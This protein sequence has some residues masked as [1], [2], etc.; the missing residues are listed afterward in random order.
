MAECSIF[1]RWFSSNVYLIC[2]LFLFLISKSQSDDVGVL[3]QLKS[4]LRSADSPVFDTWT[5][6]NS[7]CNFTGVTCDSNHKVTEINLSLQNLSGPVSFDLICSLESLEKIS[8]GSNFLYGSI[9]DHLSNCTS[10]QHLD[11]GMNYFS[12][13]VP[14]L[15]S[16]TKLELL[17]LNHCGFSGSFP[18]SS[19]A[20]LTSLGFL[21]LGDNDFDRSPFPL[22]LLKLEKLYW[23]YL[24]NC[25]IEGQIPDGIGNLTLL[26]NLEL[27]YNN[28]VGSIP[29]GI[30]RLSKLNQLELYTNGLTGK[31]PVGFGNLTNLVK[32]D[33]STNYIEGDLSELRSLTQ[34]ASLQL[35]ENQ[36][37]GEV[38]QEFGE[39]KFLT[40]F[41]LYTN[42]LT[43][44]LPEKIGSWSEFLYIDVSGNF[45]TGPIPPDMC[46]GGKLSKLLMLQNGFTGGIPASYGN[47]LS[48]TRLRVS[49]NSLSGEV[50]SGIWGLPKVTIIDL[51]LNQFEG[52]VAPSIG[53]AKSLAELLLANNQFSGELPQR[54]SEAASLVKIDITSNKLSE[55]IPATIGNL[56]K[57]SYLHL[58]FNSF[59]GV[60]PDSLGSCA[61][62]NDIN[63]AHNSFSG[64]IPA[65]LGSLPSLN[66]LN[67][68]NN[69]FVGEIPL[70]FTSLPLNLLDLSNNRLVGHIPDSLSIDAFNGSFDGN[71]GL[72]SESL[73]SFR[74]C[75]S[76][77]GMSGKIKTVIYCF[78]AIAC[79]LIVTLTCC[80]FLRFRHKNGEIPVKRSD[81]WDMKLF[82][83]LSFSEEQI[84]KALKHENLVGKGGSGNVY[85]V[86]LHCGMQLAVKHIWNQDS[87]SRNSCRSTAAILAKGKGKGRS[88]EYD[89]EVA[90]LSSARHVNVVKLYC[91]I[92]TEDS[93]LLVYEYLPN[94]SLWDRLHTGQRIKMDWM[95]RYE[96][97][98]GAAK[99]LEYLHHGC[100]R[101]IIH[102]DV[103]SSNILL[104]ADLKPKIADFGLA[105]ILQANEP[106]ARES[107]HVIAGTPGYIAP[108]YAYACSV[109]EKSDVYSFGVVLMELVTGKKP[110]E[111]EFGD[112]KD[113][114]SWI[115]SKLRSEHRTIELVDKS[116]SEALR[117][118]AVKVL[119]IAI[120]CTSRT[121]VLRPSMKMVV[122]MLENAE[123]C[124]LSS[125]VVNTREV[126]NCKNKEVLYRSS[127]TTSGSS[128]F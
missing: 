75:S 67:L 74:F 128:Q 71:S 55:E 72:C 52:P 110:V 78:I 60:V 116:I 51:N 14:D 106:N 57:L 81:S 79:V 42:K 13:K 98:L 25:S 62:L 17:N 86:V 35:F 84:L 61:S 3:M 115:Y 47:C 63:L 58:E 112:N 28:L 10:L 93:N 85:K 122:Q 96:I 121:P 91:S 2:A 27:S 127:S 31:I 34:L 103:K 114:V 37:S 41:S 36:F 12:G 104:D 89:A 113:I 68:S 39:L 15:S 54:I 88:K 111:P 82:Y 24:S 90:T 95:A 4:T 50:P 40:E 99:G 120:H 33:V 43:G 53:D 23:I 101:P 73:R 59:S 20:N 6:Q 45:L 48:L 32:F 5:W 119:K 109:N 70:S 107:T 118:D 123:P 9:S 56:K 100:D 105:K 66:F 126:Y 64:N 76:D 38:P 97:A 83:V 22:E 7:A 69:Q 29:N 16:L 11:L 18:W 125:I 65:S 124:K 87:V 108:E 49:N 80:L 19:L 46:K 26:E 94:G 77:S 8:L 92:T 30:T 117:E 21:S 102:R 1:R 44:P